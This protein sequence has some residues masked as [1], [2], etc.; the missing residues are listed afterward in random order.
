[1]KTDTEQHLVS[2]QRHNTTTRNTHLPDLYNETK[3][4][5][6]GAIFFSPGKE[7]TY[8]TA[9]CFKDKGATPKNIISD[10]NGNFQTLDIGI[11]GKKLTI[12]N[13]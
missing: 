10:D 13:I 4:L 9:I 11:N 2:G 5:W 7:N 8:T 1:M 3:N 12:T 6:P